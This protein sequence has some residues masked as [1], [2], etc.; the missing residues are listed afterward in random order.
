MVT[1]TYH[2]KAADD[3][4]RQFTVEW[5]AEDGRKRAQVFRATPAL[6]IERWRAKGHEVIEVDETQADPG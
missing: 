4:R 6:H 1:I 3:G 2:T 5:E